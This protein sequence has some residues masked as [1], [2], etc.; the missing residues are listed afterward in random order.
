MAKLI[1]SLLLLTVLYALPSKAGYSIVFP[2]SGS[3]LEA[4]Y[5][6]NI[7]WT[8]TKD[9][10]TEPAIDVILTQGPPDNLMPLMTICKDIDPTALLCQFSIPT[11][12]KSAIDYALTIGKL[13]ANVGYSSYFTIKGVGVLAQSNNGCPN[14]GGHKCTDPLSPCCGIDGY[15]GIGPGFCDKGCEPKFSYGGTCNAKPK[16]KRFVK[17]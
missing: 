10:P 15:C 11:T 6:Y 14:M 3:V 9:T 17:F 13:T 4:G 7:T 2:A 8:L 5:I 1:L 12:T 16:R